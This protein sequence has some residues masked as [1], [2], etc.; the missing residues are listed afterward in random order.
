MDGAFSESAKRFY[1]AVWKKLEEENIPFTFHW[2]KV[3]ELN[4]ALLT[5]MY[6]GKVDVWKAARKSVLDADNLKVF[7]N[8]LLKEWGLDV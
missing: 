5:K 7:S 8:P 4:P 3:T 6:G 2:G 1:A